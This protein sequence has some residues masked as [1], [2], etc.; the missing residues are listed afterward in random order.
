VI[1]SD[2][3]G[4]SFPTSSGFQVPLAGSSAYAIVVTGASQGAFGA[5]Q[6]TLQGCNV[7]SDIGDNASSPWHTLERSSSLS[8]RRWSRPW[9]AHMAFLCWAGCRGPGDGE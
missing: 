8:V 7:V 5:Y 2:R 3:L 6:L 4:S 1:A 9:C